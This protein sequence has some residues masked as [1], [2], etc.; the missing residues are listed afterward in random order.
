MEEEEKEKA[1]EDK[2]GEEEEEVQQT[3]VRV[4]TE[5]TGVH[6]CGRCTGVVSEHLTFS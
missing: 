1:V 4:G 3:K 6:S 2:E 5:Q